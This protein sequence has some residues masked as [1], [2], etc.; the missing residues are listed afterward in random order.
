MHKIDLFVNCI[1]SS[2]LIFCFFYPFSSIS[3]FC[4]SILLSFQIGFFIYLLFFLG[5]TPNIYAPEITV[6]AF[7]NQTYLSLDLLILRLHNISFQGLRFIKQHTRHFKSMS[8]RFLITDEKI[9]RYCQIM[10]NKWSN[11]KIQVQKEMSK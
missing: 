11:F 2:W 1:Q 6:V 5:T 10:D 4:L 9:I 3:Y 8:I 7:F